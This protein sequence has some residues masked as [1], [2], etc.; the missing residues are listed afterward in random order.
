ME[1]WKSR[2][3]VHLKCRVLTFG[4]SA[5]VVVLLSSSSVSFVEKNDFCVLGDFF[6]LI[7]CRCWRGLLTRTD[8]RQPWRCWT[9]AFWRV[10]AI[11]VF[12]PRSLHALKY[13]TL[14]LL[15]HSLWCDFPPKRVGLLL[16]G[17]GCLLPANNFICSS[18]LSHTH[19]RARSDGPGDARGVRQ[20]SGSGQ[21]AC[22]LRRLEDDHRQE[23]GG[24]G[25]DVV[26]DRAGGGGACEQVCHAG[27]RRR[28]RDTPAGRQTGRGGEKRRGETPNEPKRR[29]GKENTAT[30]HF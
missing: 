19:A 3:V 1:P 12:F 9:R 18:R 25:G 11:A 23:V 6:L 14:A 22:E 7:R 5:A 4:L 21:G 28:I 13:S 2:A 30:S 16:T 10:V 8:G 29:R 17:R 26:A 24:G 27:V 15:T 20:G